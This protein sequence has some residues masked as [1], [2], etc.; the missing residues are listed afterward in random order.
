MKKRN[1]K[2]TLEGKKKSQDNLYEEKNRM[3]IYT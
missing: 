1:G 2:E 3:Q